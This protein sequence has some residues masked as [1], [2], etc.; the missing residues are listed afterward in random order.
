MRLL[1]LIGL[2]STLLLCSVSVQAQEQWKKIAPL[3]ESF[4]VTMP[5]VAQNVSRVVPLSA[6]RTVPA[7]VLYSVANGRRYAIASFVRTT[8]DRVTALSNFPEFAIAM[9]WSLTSAEGTNGSLTFQQD[10]SEGSTI[11]KQY[12][13]QLG[14][15]KGVARFIATKAWLYALVV[16]GADANDSDAQRFLKS[17]VTGKMNNDDEPDITNVITKSG[18]YSAQEL[19]PEPWPRKA[20]PITGG[21]LNGK[22][23]SLA[24]PK[25]PKAA[26][27]NRDEGHVRV[28][29]V[30]DEFGKVVSAEAVEGAESLREAATNAAYKSLFTPTRLMGQPVKVSGI[31][32]Y[33]FVAQ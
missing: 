18:G 1:K 11:I 20:A 14:E 4:T 27:K 7:R 29:I 19:P 22:A 32:V 24:K 26:R 13:L 6:T 12:H 10:L 23:L 2:A 17:F 30:I 15:H 8:D 31:I 16:M 25:Y 28:R 5:T 21:V 33:N 9:E 3:G